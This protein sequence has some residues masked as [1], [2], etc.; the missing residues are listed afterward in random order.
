MRGCWKV[1][2]YLLH[3]ARGNT[4]RR[5]FFECVVTVVEPSISPTMVTCFSFFESVPGVVGV[6]KFTV[7]PESNIPKAIFLT[8]LL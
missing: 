2:I 6:K 1:P 3:A 4:G 7:A 5:R 8:V